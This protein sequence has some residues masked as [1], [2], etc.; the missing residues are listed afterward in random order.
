MEVEVESGVKL[1]GFTDVSAILGCGV[2]ALVKRGTVIYIG[3]SKSLYGRIYTHR[4]AA[5]R[6][7]KG[8]GIPTWLPVKGFVFD[9]VLVFPCHIDRL[10]AVEHEMIN[11]YKPRYN[12]SLKNN[13]PVRTPIT[14]ASPSG[15]LVVL[16]R[17]RPQ[18]ERRV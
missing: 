8:K 3:K 4:S 1:E 6:A 13:L 11:R 17:P 9:Q 7:S 10:D 12:E 5:T 18:I 2:Y 14:I 16:N 15:S